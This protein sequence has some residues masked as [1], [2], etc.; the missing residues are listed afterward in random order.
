[1]NDSGDIVGFD[2]Q[3]GTALLST[4]SG[5]LWGTIQGVPGLEFSTIPRAMNRY[6]H[7]AGVA[8]QFFP[9]H[10]FIS[11]DSTS[12]ATDLGTLDAAGEGVTVADGIND[13]D[14]VVGGAL[15]PNILPPQ[16]FLHDG[17]QMINLNTDLW[18]PGGWGLREA[19]AVNDAGQIVG[20]GSLNGETHAF[21]LQPMTQ[22]QSIRQRIGCQLQLSR[23]ETAFTLN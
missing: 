5:H 6:G 12:P 18:N 14:W 16:A 1:M 21:L 2:H 20:T 3:S 23:V 10:A 19:T 15:D 9:V 22:L 13:Y 17:T 11:R 8:G 4:N 7:V